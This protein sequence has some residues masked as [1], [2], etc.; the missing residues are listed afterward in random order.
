MK[1]LG[2][3]M[4]KRFWQT[5]R[6]EDCYARYRRELHEMWDKNCTG[7]IPALRY[8]D[9]KRFE[10]EGGRDEY[11]TPYFA[12]RHALDASALLSLIYPDCP[13]YLDR[14]MDEI[15]AICDEYT[16]CVPAHHGPVGVENPYRIDLFAAETGFALA[17]IYTMLEDRLEPLIKQRVKSE[18]DRRIIE[19]FSRTEPYGFWERGTNNW[20]AV[21]VGSV[22]S[23]VML[24]RPELTESLKPRFDRAME[25]YLSGFEEDGVC[26][27]GCGYW[28]YGF[29][30]FVVYA[31][32]IRTF[33]EGKTDYFKRE[34]VKTIAT[35]LQKMFLSGRASVSFADGHP[36]LSYHLGLLH[37]L[38]G[39]YPNDVRVY[40]KD[41]S[42]NYDHCGR[43]CLQL[44]SAIW[45]DP[46]WDTDA[47]PQ[48]DPP[49][50][51]YAPRSEWYVKKTAAYSLAAKGGHN[52]EPHNH[53]DVGAFIFAKDGKQRLADPGPAHYCKAY[54][55]G[56]TR[57]DFFH[58]SSRGHSLP[59]VDGQ[60]QKTGKTY[61]AHGATVS[62]DGFSLD[63]A[64]AYG[65]DTLT[66]LVRSFACTE[67]AVTLT[68]T[69]VYTG[70][71]TLTERLVFGSLPCLTQAGRLEA[72]GVTVTYDPALVAEA[73][74]TEETF[75]RKPTVYTADLTLKKGV[76][77]I[78]MIIK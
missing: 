34:K 54:F 23:T 43:F 40:S 4:D 25:C 63:M 59:I 44:R 42:Y 16:W 60:Y 9:F 72:E 24:M 78:V 14:L 49:S 46:A 74:I 17:E 27:E 61:R 58:A 62:E 11:E 77:E 30:F 19:P 32:M 5:V 55:R 6:E 71:G 33:T 35:F 1:L 7:E 68:D 53:N 31:D 47:E 70:E 64:G 18:I 38:K 73:V 65:L 37:Y 76:R 26:T 15:F 52:E 50:V 57:Y 2:R 8:S 3:A 12:R 67:E 45:Y 41:Y 20:T 22:A 36:T 39:E 10:T 29:G 66:S 51:Y 21:C 69:F 13:E 56:E 28:H 48:N 75:D